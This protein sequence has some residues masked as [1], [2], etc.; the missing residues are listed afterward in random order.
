MN[1]IQKAVI[2]LICILSV[3]VNTTYARVKISDKAEISILTCSAGD[4]LYSAFGHSAIRIKDPENRM[5]L[6][7]NYGVFDFDTPHFY[8]KFANGKLNY[9]MSGSKYKRFL[10]SYMRENRSV[11]EQILKLSQ[12]EKQLLVDALF[13]NYKP[14]NRYYKYDFFYDNCATRVFNIVKENIRGKFSYRD[15]KNPHKTFRQYL[16]HYLNNS[17]WIETGLKVILGMPADKEASLEQS[18]FLPD[19][20]YLLFKS[21]KVMRANGGN[22]FIGKEKLLLDRSN[23]VNSNKFIISPFI[24]FCI[25]LVFFASLPFLFKRKQAL[26]NVFYRILLFTTGIVGLLILYL[27]FVT[28]HSVTGNN[29]NILWSFPGVLMLSLIRWKNTKWVNYIVY[30]QLALQII[31]LLGWKFLPQDFPLASIPFSILLIFI[32]TYIKFIYEKK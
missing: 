10:Y 30:I 12:D 16:H 13:E 14:E 9:Q 7:F 5:D 32:L 26:I 15:Y 23:S 27:W 28:D 1:K 18:T 6:V 19:Y 22:A 8:L 21:T 17:P 29:L 2:I 25:I 20:L 4:E 11:T 24:C 31:F 3:K